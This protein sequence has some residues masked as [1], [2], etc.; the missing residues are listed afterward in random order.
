LEQKPTRGKR[1]KKSGGKKKLKKKGRGR[2][3]KKKKAIPKLFRGS[4]IET[5]KTQLLRRAQ[6]ERPTGVGQWGG[7]FPTK[8]HALERKP[9]RR[10]KCG[11]H[12]QKSFS[13]QKRGEKND[14]ERTPNEGELL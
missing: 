2:T 1:G 12:H 7:E 8:H 13:P 11:N 6:T 4:S 10:R 3:Q 5:R 14:W 9:Q